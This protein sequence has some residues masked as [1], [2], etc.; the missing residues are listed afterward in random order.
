[1]NSV[2]VWEEDVKIPT[3]GIGKEE[4]NPVFIE[5]RVYQGSCGAVY[6]YPVIEKIEDTLH[7]QSYR[8]LWLENEYIKTMILPELGG[9]VQMAYDKTKKRHFVYYNHVIKPALVG[10]TG[11][12][13]SGGIEF[14][15][16]Q[17]H[18]PST[19]LPTD[20]SIEKKDDGSA[21]VWV[22]ERERM[23]HQKSTVG[24]TLR[25]GHAFLE[26]NVSLF[27]P[28]PVP[29]TFLWWANPAVAVN[30]QYQSVFP[31]DVNA[32]FDHGKRDVST[33]PIAT[34]TY[35]KVDYSKGV[36]ISRYKNL[37][38]PTSYMAVHSDYDFV[39][40]YEND[41]QAGL[42]HVADHHISPGKKQWTWGCGDFGRAWDRNLTNDDGP[43]IE[44]M[45]GVY[46][47]NQP[48]FSWLQPYEEKSFTQY[49]MP[50]R[51][52]GVIKNATKDILMNI[53]P[54]KDNKEKTDCHRLKIF[55]TSEQKDLYIIIKQKD[56]T[57]ASYR[58]SVSPEKIFEQD[59]P[60]RE[61][62][63]ISI[64]ILSNDKKTVLSWT[65]PDKNSKP[66]PQPAKAA[67]KP[68]KYKST[69]QLF[70]TG[71]HLE[72]YRHATY[73]P[74]DYYMEALKRDSGDIRNNNAMGL[75]L[76]RKGQFRK[77]EKY[78]RAAIGTLTERNPNPYDGE[79]YYNLGLSLKLQGKPDEAYDCFYKSCW[80]AAWQDA[81]YFA[82]AQIS[83]QNGNLENALYEIGKS[84]VRNLHNQQAMHLKT[85]I[86]RKKGE[87]DKALNQIRESLK[88]DKFNFGCGFELYLLTGDEKDRLSLNT[89]M[90]RES[91]NYEE[92]MLDYA[93]A[94]CWEEALSVADTALEYGR[95]IDI[96]VSYYK[97][98]FL[99]KLG[100]TAKAEE[101]AKEAEK[102]FHTVFFPNHADAIIALQSV[103][104][105]EPPTP[106]ALYLLGNIWYDKRQ[107]EEALSAWEESAA[108][109]RYPTTLRNLSLI[110]FNKYGDAAKAVSLLEEAYKL[111]TGDSR[112]L[113]E[114]D[115]LYK[116]L[117]YPHLKRLEFLNRHKK[118]A[119]ERDDLY[120][121]Y[122]TL[123]NQ[124]GRYGEALNMILSRKFHPW[125]GG[126][127]KVTT[128]YIFSHKGLMMNAM[129]HEN[130]E[131]AYENIYA[132]FEYP[133]NLGEGKL[134]T[135]LE[136]D[137]YFYCG[138][139]LS[140][141]GHEEDAKKCF[142]KAAKGNIKP[143][144]AMY[145]NDQN[146]DKL[147]YQ[148]M[149]YL[150][151]GNE[152]EAEK[153]FSSLSGFGKKH[154]KDKFTM[155]YFAV[156]LPDL[157]I[158]EDDMNKRN[159]INC[160]YLK[161]LGYLGLN[162]K[163]NATKCFNLALKMDINHEGILIHTTKFWKQMANHHLFQ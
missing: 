160:Y 161:A 32:V 3:Y 30:D 15:W 144:A 117:N 90:R 70:L 47:D 46:T 135:T 69:E 101:T 56:K 31:S 64:E 163:G 102:N 108:T 60:C 37:P 27:N 129:L 127:G 154:L 149:A 26:I 153:C 91:R 45:T 52:L 9:R 55:A 34:G 142:A 78:L 59:V 48:D 112:I 86:L 72:Q 156:S 146:P 103:N 33:F 119:F 122:I 162:K 147:F 16:P 10:L 158:W 104:K 89:L 61:L 81:G 75:W 5:K 121:E 19:F 68:E 155:D 100:E 124:L 141:M 42:L 73:N 87:K 157:L 145:Y 98:W 29:Q 105:L 115:Q 92:L 123:L 96:I 17:H 80:N 74:V 125:E 93:D 82:L 49:F 94:G 148:G 159:K 131:E 150:K 126:E 99:I 20:Y 97:C 136:N 43:Y 116:R 106:K 51:E 58:T 113:M 23:F 62:N 139:A 14:N 11:P 137:L 143:A 67:M 18:R 53:V 128:Q 28:T 24:F 2:K 111:N 85:I 13:I 21:I 12:W 50:Y 8:A 4:K 38:V 130:Y 40:G 79:P 83:L 76:I 132:C 110:Y 77:A 95:D 152:L 25:P 63:D 54:V 84:L 65:A 120:L 39:G 36:D 151:L 134:I 109:E 88:T 22:S 114:I 66:A 138:L 35:Y 41:T 7:I 71:Q 57:L 107:Y 1:M 6:P 44:L 133:R 118:T 140:G